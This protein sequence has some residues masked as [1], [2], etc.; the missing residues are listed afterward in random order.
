MTP[1]PLAIHLGVAIAVKLLL[2]GCLWLVFVRGDTVPVGP[3]AMAARA[4]VSV[5]DFQFLAGED[6]E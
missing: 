2:L 4:G 1:S 5:P 6:R 3:A